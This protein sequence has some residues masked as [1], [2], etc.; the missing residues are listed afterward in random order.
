MR[1]TLLLRFR[2]VVV[3]NREGNIGGR[4]VVDR[5]I[6]SCGLTT[7]RL[8]TKRDSLPEACL[9]TASIVQWPFCEVVLYSKKKDQAGGDVL[10]SASL[11]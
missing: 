5:R 11:T 7:S 2:M 8:L 6:M 9:S 10:L 1:K 4:I 3:W